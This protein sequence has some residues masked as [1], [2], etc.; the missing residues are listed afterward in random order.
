VIYYVPCDGGL[1]KVRHY[2][3]AYRYDAQAAA[4]RAAVDEAHCSG[5]KGYDGQVLVQ[6][7]HG[8]WRTEW[9]YGHDP[10]PSKG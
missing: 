9:A 4:I 10:Y 7:Q 3:I 2:D 1:W 5:R 6:G 8:Q